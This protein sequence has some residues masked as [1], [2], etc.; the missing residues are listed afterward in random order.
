MKKIAFFLLLLIFLTPMV[1]GASDGQYYE[2]ARV[3]SIVSEFEMEAD[4]VGEVYQ[5]VQKITL[6]ILS[7]E[8]KGQEFEVENI[9]SNN[10]LDIKLSEGQEA[11][12][13]IEKLENGELNIQIQDYWRL[14]SVIWLI[15]IFFII[16]LLVGR[17]QGLKAII[18]LLLSIFLI[19]K[20]FIPQAISGVNVVWLAFLISV[21]ITIITLL[22]IGGLN[23]KSLAAIIGTVGGL[24]VAVVLA[25]WVCD[26]ASLNGLASEESRILFSK[27]PELNI[28]GVLFAGIII[29]ALG[30]VMDVAISIASSVSEVNLANKKLSFWELFKSGMNVG[31]DIMGTMTNTLIFAYVGASFALLL[32]FYQVNESYLKFLNFDFV[33]EEIVRSIAGSIGL[34]LTIPIT[35]FIISYLLHKKK[36]K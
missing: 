14:S 18:S 9:L 4:E 10:P 2:K 5:E 12:V 35:S 3:I 6:K 25:F 16:L 1:A 28:R 11:L 36:N 24:L 15:L 34:V 20:V 19:F 27:F 23:K 8:Y 29:G 30:A 7:G 22:I 26:L 31:K 17:K 13:F 33:A 32:L 21:S